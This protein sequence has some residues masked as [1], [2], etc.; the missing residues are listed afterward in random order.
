[1]AK[2]AFQFLK[3]ID[4]QRG[5]EFRLACDKHF[6]LSTVFKTPEEQAAIHAKDSENEKAAEANGN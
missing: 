5:E 4:S 6:E 2:K 1:M 3:S